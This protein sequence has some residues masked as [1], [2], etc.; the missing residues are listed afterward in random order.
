MDDL[1]Q[2]DKMNIIHRFKPVETEIKAKKKKDKYK[3]KR[4]R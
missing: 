4:E 3:K 2:K 1:K